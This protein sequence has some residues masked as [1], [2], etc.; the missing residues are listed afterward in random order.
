MVS[1]R[2]IARSWTLPLAL[3][4]CGPTKVVEISTTTG[5]SGVTD[6]GVTAS[7]ASSSA[8]A[9]STSAATTTGVT[10]GSEAP[11]TIAL[12][13]ECVF[14]SL[15]DD[16]GEPV[17]CDPH[18]EMPCPE[19]QKCSAAERTPG[20]LIFTGTLSC[21][22]ILGDKQKG[23]P[24]DLG[25]DPVD[26]LD[27]C[28]SGLICADIH[29]AGQKTGVCVDFCDPAIKDGP[30]NQA[31]SDPQDF[32][33]SPG[34][35]DCLLS[36]CVPACDPLIQNCPD[37][38][39]CVFT[40]FSTDPA[41]DC[42][43]VQPDLPGVGESCEFTY[44]CNPDASCVVSEEVANPACLGLEV[45]CTP[46][47]DMNEPNTCPGAAMGEVCKPFFPDPFDPLLDPW[48][49][50]YDRLGICGIP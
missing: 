44:R 1:M 29:L 21:F 50:Q 35:Q 20:L 6:A 47:C 33:L 11:T 15:P 24:C 30:T 39:G 18:A 34:C 38:T 9:T 23:E 14:L 5:T 13:S 8:G 42:E 16:P 32:C 26:G 31:C 10:T 41:F 40:Y 25:E 36:L 43:A 46:F 2:V 12:T 3:G 22:P 4:A 17:E 48:S 19:C 37:G 45:C 28:A 7:A 27:E 49:V